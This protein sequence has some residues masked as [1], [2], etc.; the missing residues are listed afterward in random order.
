MRVRTFAD[1]EGFLRNTQAELEA[2]E[3]AN[4]LML[5]ICLRLVRTPERVQRATCLKTVQDDG[6]LV[7]AAVMT[8]PYKL[9]VYG[10]RGDLKE[11]ARAF[12][13]KRPPVFKGK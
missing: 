9:V 6:G 13:E 7:M 1:A 12:A 8:P 4:S 5:G 11:G 2:N 10:H 3:A